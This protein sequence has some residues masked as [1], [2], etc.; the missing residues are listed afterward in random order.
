MH[1]QK[2]GLA[3]VSWISLDHGREKWRTFV[4]AAMNLRV[5]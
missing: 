4:E 3:V 2:M 1:L 5:L